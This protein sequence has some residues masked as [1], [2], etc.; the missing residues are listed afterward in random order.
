MNE[1]SETKVWPG[2]GFR[3]DSHAVSRAV[4]MSLRNHLNHHQ[5]IL[6]SLMHIISVGPVPYEAYHTIS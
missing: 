4:L 2:E 6:Q 1:A 3:D 5:I